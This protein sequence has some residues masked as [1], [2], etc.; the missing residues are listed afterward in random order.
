[1]Y[2]TYS[3]THPG[4]PSSLL[5]LQRTYEEILRNPSCPVSGNQFPAQYHRNL[6][7]A[8]ESFA[9]LRQPDGLH[10]P[11]PAAYP[12]GSGN[13]LVLCHLLRIHQTD[14]CFRLRYFRFLRL[15][16]Y[17]SH[18]R[19][20]FRHYHLHLRHCNHFHFRLFLFL[21]VVV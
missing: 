21:T 2:N 11:I 13:R 17:L 1:M 3:Q 10:P 8:G 6:F 19:F 15:R 18:Y 9:Y 14:Y 16:H 12:A 7:P 20:L 4:L 5:L